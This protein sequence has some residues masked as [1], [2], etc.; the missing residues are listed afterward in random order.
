MGRVQTRINMS[1]RG[2]RFWRAIPNNRE[3]EA[4]RGCR[5]W[6][7]LESGAGLKFWL[8]KMRKPANRNMTT[9]GK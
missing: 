7:E 2:K 3:T 5:V 9:R 8:T 6:G 4:G 1:Q